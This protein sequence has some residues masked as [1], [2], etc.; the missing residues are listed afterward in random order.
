MPYL[1]V[2][3]R[4]MRAGLVALLGLASRAALPLDAWSVVA[5]PGAAVS[6]GFE[7]HGV[8]SDLI[9]SYALALC[10]QAPID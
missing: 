4:R 7:T 9:L 2:T 5:Y 6:Y 1:G 10:T 3:V 8:V